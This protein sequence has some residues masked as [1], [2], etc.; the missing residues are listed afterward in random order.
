MVLHALVRYSAAYAQTLKRPAGT[1][2]GADPK[3]PKLVAP[4]PKPKQKV[5]GE[6]GAKAEGKSKAKPKPKAAGADLSDKLKEM[7]AKAGGAGGSG[8]NAA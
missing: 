1:E 8:G 6:A 7:L 4:T 3:K 5:E 2:A